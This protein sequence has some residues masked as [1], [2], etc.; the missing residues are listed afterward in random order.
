MRFGLFIHLDDLEPFCFNFVYFNG[1]LQLQS[2]RVFVASIFVTRRF[3][4]CIQI[5]FFLYIIYVKIFRRMPRRGG[6][7]RI[8]MDDPVPEFDEPP[9]APAAPRYD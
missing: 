3:L 4:F 6:G 2:I 9:F 7:K 5:Y 1:G 8:R